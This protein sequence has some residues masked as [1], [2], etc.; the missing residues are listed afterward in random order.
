M[1]ITLKTMSKKKR[2]LKA[3]EKRK[4]LTSASIQKI[5]ERYSG[6]IPPSAEF[7]RYNNTLPGAA[8]R[9]LKMS[10]RQQAFD[11]NINYREQWF[12]YISKYFAQF[13][14]LIIALAAIASGTY[15][16]ISGHS[17]TGIGILI[18]ALATFAG[19][20]IFGKKKT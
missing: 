17:V 5:E 12:Y 1:L 10:E 19:T 14:V 3:P 6:P 16:I 20:V 2:N 9:I 7:E 8:D 11:H 18:T 4:P 15:L 13:I